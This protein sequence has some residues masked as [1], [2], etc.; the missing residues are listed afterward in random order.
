M[1]YIEFF[2]RVNKALDDSFTYVSI[3]KIWY[4][5]LTRMNNRNHILIFTSLV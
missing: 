1:R 4:K 3:S 5:F 2:T